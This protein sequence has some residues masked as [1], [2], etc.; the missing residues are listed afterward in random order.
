ME[1]AQASPIDLARAEGIDEDFEGNWPEDNDADGRTTIKYT[2]QPKSWEQIREQ[3]AR[4]GLYNEF[5]EGGD[6]DEDFEG[7]WEE[8][9]ASIKQQANQKAK[10]DNLVHFWG[11]QENMAN[12]NAAR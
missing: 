6:V 1:V 2:G 12:H 11:T 3:L 10:Y 7:G 4:H 9:D 5:L 8:D